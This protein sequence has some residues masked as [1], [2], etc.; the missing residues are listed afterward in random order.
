LNDNPI[1]VQTLLTGTIALIL[2]GFIWFRSIRRTLGWLGP[3]SLFASGLIVLY[4]IPSLYW[5][6]RPW[7]YMYP[8]YFDGLPL[9]M[10]GAIILAIPFLFDSLRRR[11]AQSMRPWD[12]L[13]HE[14]YGDML[15]LALIPILL[16]IAYRLYLFSQGYQGRNDREVIYILD[17]ENLALIVSN[18]AFYFPIFYYLLIL[19][20]NRLQRR[21]GM[22][23]WVVDGLMQLMTLHRWAILI[24]IIR[25]CIFLVILGHKFTRRQIVMIATACVITISI[26]GQAGLVSMERTT[27]VRYLGPLDFA[28]VIGESARYYFNTGQ[29]KV[30]ENALLDLIDDTMNRLYLARSASAVMKSTPDVIPYFYGGTFRHI[31][32]AWIP[33]YFWPDKPTMLEIHLLTILVMPGD[34]GTNPTGTIAEL[35]VNYGFVAIFLG[36]I[37]CLLLCR[38]QE[39]VL[40]RKGNAL[41]AW[42]CVYP[43][44]SIW[45]VWADANLTQRITEGLR[46]L[47]VFVIVR[48]FLRMAAHSPAQRDL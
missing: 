20:G 30:G 13:V 40:Q 44:M 39:S 11:Q 28:S 26:I 5:Q 23:F 19:L 45:F 6:F 42:L 35:F 41:C 8:P 15:W 9:V 16:G 37:L 29:S 48:I 38:W 1:V 3:T 36:G 46:G 32:Y 34:M 18:F 22:I 7:N 10:F 21:S 4:I 31:L 33:R 47:L 12:Q 25:S 2:W 27:Y 24:F 17:S 14:N 43:L